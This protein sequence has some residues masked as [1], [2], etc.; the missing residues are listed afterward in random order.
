MVV[1]MADLV[2][3]ASEAGQQFT[4]IPG[5]LFRNHDALHAGVTDLKSGQETSEVPTMNEHGDVICLE[6][7]PYNNSFGF[8]LWGKDLDESHDA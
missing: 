5:A 8:R 6:K 3:V 2:I 1:A 7:R 4:R